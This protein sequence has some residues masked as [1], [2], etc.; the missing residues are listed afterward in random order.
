MFWKDIAIFLYVI[1]VK[2]LNLNEYEL[3]LNSTFNIS[4]F[5]GL[6]WGTVLENA[7]LGASLSPCDRK[8]C[9]VGHTNTRGRN[10]HCSILLPDPVDKATKHNYNEK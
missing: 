4:N 9:D 5:E 3:F 7:Q 8:H 2:F 1:L 10:C 6:S